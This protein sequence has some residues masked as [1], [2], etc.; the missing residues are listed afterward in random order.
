[1]IF[2]NASVR[3]EHVSFARGIPQAKGRE[4]TDPGER[5]VLHSHLI[6]LQ[7]ILKVRLSN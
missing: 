3:V 6:T 5:N 1:M 2:L 7:D 4:L